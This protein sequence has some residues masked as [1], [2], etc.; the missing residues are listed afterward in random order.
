[1]AV[2]VLAEGRV[3]SG[4]LRIRKVGCALVVE[5]AKEHLALPFSLIETSKRR[6]HFPKRSE[7]WILP[8]VMVAH[9]QRRAA[10]G[11]SIQQSPQL[12]ECLLRRGSVLH[13]Y[14]AGTIR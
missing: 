7:R 8:L 14:W 9:V 13:H 5:V 1:M 6:C 12:T 10:A 4:G 2:A 11:Q 3:Q